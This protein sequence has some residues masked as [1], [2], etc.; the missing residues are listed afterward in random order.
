MRTACFFPKIFPISLARAS[1]PD[2][3]RLAVIDHTGRKVL[4]QTLSAGATMAEVDV[5]ALAA[6]VYLL[7]VMDGQSPLAVKTFVVE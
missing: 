5:R 4:S 3:G 1:L 7:R 6:G 2:A